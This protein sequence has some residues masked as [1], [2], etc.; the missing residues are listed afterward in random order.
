MALSMRELVLDRSS[1]VPLGTQLAWKLRSAIVSEQLGPLERLPG[2]RELAAAA[3]VNVNTVRAVYARLAQ[4]GLIVSERGR[5]TFV[6]ERAAEY[7][8]LRELAEETASDARR[9]GIDPRE[10]AELLYAGAHTATPAD[11]APARRTLRAQIAALEQ[12]LVELEAELPTNDV[13]PTAAPARPA[14]GARLLTAAELEDTRARLASTVAAL[15][16]KIKSQHAP[17][18]RTESV[19]KVPA[20]YSAWPEFF[21]SKPGLSNG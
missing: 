17:A 4:Q 6:S 2:V 10:L 9:R 14:R 18:A 12:E 5:G 13:P 7:A 20:T 21:A 16:T 11:E 1:D 8:E 15:R 3:S 19:T